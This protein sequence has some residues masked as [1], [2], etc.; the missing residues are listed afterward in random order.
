M[1]TGYQIVEPT[2]L[3]PLIKTPS[4]EGIAIAILQWT[5]ETLRCRHPELVDAVTVEVI[6][7]QYLGAYPAIGIR[8]H[9]AITADYGPAISA[10]IDNILEQ[11]TMSDFLSFM[12]QNN[13]DWHEVWKTMEAASRAQ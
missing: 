13:T 11:Y 9:E 3:D 5:I 6:C 8:Y 1:R 2:G 10:A 12:E 7:V 4:R